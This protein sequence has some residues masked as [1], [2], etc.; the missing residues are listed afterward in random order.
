[1]SGFTCPKASHSSCHSAP[2]RAFNL[3][4]IAHP[5]SAAGEP[6]RSAVP[7]LAAQVKQPC[8]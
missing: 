5:S 8:K 2:V 4:S 6:H 1:M 7:E 3:K